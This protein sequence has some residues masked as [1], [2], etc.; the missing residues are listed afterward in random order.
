VTFIIIQ[1]LKKA[2]SVTVSLSQKLSEMRH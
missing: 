2:T 1:E